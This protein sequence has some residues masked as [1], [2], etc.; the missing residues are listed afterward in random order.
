MITVSGN[1]TKTRRFQQQLPPAYLGQNLDFNYSL[2]LYAP[3][4]N[5]IFGLKSSDGTVRSQYTLKSGL[6]F[7]YQDRFITT[8]QSGENKFD[9]GLKK[10][11]IFNLGVEDYYSYQKFNDRLISSEDLYSDYISK[12]FDRFFIQ[13]LG[14]E[15]VNFDLSI[16]GFSPPTEYSNLIGIGSN[17]FSG[18]L[19]Q[20]GL[21]SYPLQSV[22][23]GLL[24]VSLA[25]SDGSVKSFQTSGSGGVHYIIS[26]NNIFSNQSINVEFDTLFG[27][28]SK[29]IIATTGS[30]TIGGESDSG[31]YL[32]LYG[33]SN[34]V[35]TKSSLE[36]EIDYYSNYDN[37]MVLELES[38]TSFAISNLSG[39]GAGILNYSGNVRKSG[40]IYSA[41]NITGTAD[42]STVG[43]SIFN[44]QYSL[45]DTTI[46]I[47]AAA[48]S[49]TTGVFFTGVNSFTITGVNIIGTYDGPYPPYIDYLFSG[50]GDAVVSHD[51][52]E[53]DEGV[54]Y[55]NEMWNGFLNSG[56]SPYFYVEPPGATSPF[57]AGGI[58][59]SA[60]NTTLFPTGVGQGMVTALKTGEGIVT[61]GVPITSF[62]GEGT[63]RTYT[64]RIEIYGSGTGDVS[65]VG[66]AYDWGAPVPIVPYLPVSDIW[67][68]GAEC[69]L[70]STT[71]RGRISN[72]I[73]GFYGTGAPLNQY[74]TWGFPTG[75]SNIVIAPMLLEFYEN[76]AVTDVVGG[77]SSSGTRIPMTFGFTGRTIGYI[78][79]PGVTMQGPVFPSPDDTGVY[80]YVG[81]GIIA[82]NG[83]SYYGRGCIFSSGSTDN[84]SETFGLYVLKG[85]DTPFEVEYSI[86]SGGYFGTYAGTCDRAFIPLPVIYPATREVVG[87]EETII[88]NSVSLEFPDPAINRTSSGLFYGYGYVPSGDID[89]KFNLY[90]SEEEGIYNLSYKQ[91]NWY[92]P[93]KFIRTEPYIY[94]AGFKKGYV[95]VDYTSADTDSSD[96]VTL[97]VKVG[98][99]TGEVN[100][101]TNQ[102]AT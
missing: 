21:N 75:P 19:T 67:G 94:E 6:V 78:N 83:N 47:S 36:F 72:G 12:P 80:P 7:D 15:N 4:S 69:T 86:Q 35:Q 91:E 37:Q 57:A 42:L 44:T 102:F 55:F 56:Y 90:Y 98:G 3:G 27:R 33:P 88:Y 2:S 10:E 73:T 59:V 68:N 49:R 62:F 81:N 71:A 65:F 79:F 22:P 93:T 16:N 53:S 40:L 58:Q 48:A 54:Y 17:L 74:Q 96:E 26:G 92:I 18:N 95:K 39:T 29:T 45:E 5:V 63:G 8:Y 84:G 60:Y 34:L 24:G 14:S 25:A 23:Y 70:D 43:N 64:S 46:N 13:N 87:T 99:K 82:T 51:Y 97:R 100:I 101:L 28:I 85:T 11:L 38:N 61:R 30:S 31:V 52:I 89:S 76:L 41:P 66:N 50:L 9:Y 1:T 32:S 20:L 77:Y